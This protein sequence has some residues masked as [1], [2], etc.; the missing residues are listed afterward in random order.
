MSQLPAHV[1]G[2]HPFH[3][4]PPV[5]STVMSPGALIPS[6][7]TIV[8]GTVVLIDS[9]SGGSDGPELTGPSNSHGH[10]VAKLSNDIADWLGTMPRYIPV[11]RLML[12]DMLAP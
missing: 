11:S 2:H 12:V 10:R 5:H 8:T 4:P 9:S 3:C 1:P 7:A 6:S